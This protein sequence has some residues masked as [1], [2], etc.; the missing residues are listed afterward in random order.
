MNLQVT[1]AD[2]CVKSLGHL[3]LHYRKKEDGPAAKKLL[4][5]LGFARVS[6]P[7][8]YPYFHYVVDSR[9]T[10][11][12]DG[13]LY[14]ME[15]PEP[16][17]ELYQAIHEALKVGQSDEH[18]AVAKVR[19]AQESDPEFDQH[20]GILYESLEAIEAAILSVKNAVQNDPEL[21]GRVKVIL[22]RA[23]PGNAEVDA[24]MNASPIFGD[25]NRHTY[26]NN[27]IQ[28]FVET[29]LFVTGA[30][31]NLFV[32]ELDYVFPGYKDNILSNPTGVPVEAH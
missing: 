18:P 17:R 16:L 8:S 24:R 4:D 27:G 30:L 26:G 22:N 14:V 13:I 21:R 31:G 12:G 20:L 5:M 19:A 32:F 9:L 25:I 10:Y 2:E 23:R 28:A 1:R 29:D 15:Q 11:H 6:S 7:A 3:A